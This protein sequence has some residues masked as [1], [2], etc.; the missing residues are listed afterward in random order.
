MWECRCECGKV[1]CVSGSNL[2]RG[3]TNSCG[4]LRSEAKKRHGLTDS[5]TWNSW[6]SMLKR[7]TAKNHTHY[8][9]Y[10]GRGISVCDSWKSFESFFADMG[11]RPVG[12]TLDR[13]DPNGDYTKDN[14]RWATFRE[15]TYNRRDAVRITIGSETGNPVYW[16]K[17]TGVSKSTIEWRH[18]RGWPP[19]EAVHGRIKP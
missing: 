2:R 3:A 18:K 19:E 12:K 17:K 5:P 9:L 11:E 13:I 15:Q 1:I 8:M 10:G 7:C 4:C 16:S 6:A 14:C